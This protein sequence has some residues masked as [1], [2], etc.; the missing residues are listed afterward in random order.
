MFDICHVNT[1]LKH[2]ISVFRHFSLLFY[3]YNKA[4]SLFD[5]TKSI[6][7]RKKKTKF[8]KLRASKNVD[9]IVRS[10]L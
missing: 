9:V 3:F 1:I 10:S 5:P 7:S 8:T 4:V 2:M 6:M